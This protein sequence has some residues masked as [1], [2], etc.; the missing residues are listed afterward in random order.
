MGAIPML[1]L[2]RP[3]SAKLV[4]GRVCSEPAGLQTGQSV[5]EC[6]VLD[7]EAGPPKAWPDWTDADTWELGPNPRSPPMQLGTKWPR[8]PLG[9]TASKRCTRS[10]MRTSGLLAFQ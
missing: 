8:S 2:D 3:L 7:P 5:T 1:G 6:E 10:R 4:N 9:R